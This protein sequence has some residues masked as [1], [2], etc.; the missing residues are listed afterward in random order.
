MR[1]I[2]AGN[3]IQTVTSSDPV[4]LI[5]VRGTAFPPSGTNGGSANVEDGMGF[6]KKYNPQPCM[7]IPL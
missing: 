6:I 1:T 3:A 7:R 4:S 5:T 2:Y